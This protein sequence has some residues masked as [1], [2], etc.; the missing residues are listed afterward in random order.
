[1]DKQL[2]T[3]QKEINLHVSDIK[4][5]QGLLSRLNVAK[6]KTQD[7]LRR[8]KDRARKTMEQLNS[9][10]RAD[11]AE[12]SLKG[13]ATLAAGATAGITGGGDAGGLM[14]FSNVKRRDLGAMM[15]NSLGNTLNS[16]SSYVNNVLPLKILLKSSQMTRFEISSEGAKA[17]KPVNAARFEP[18]GRNSGLQAKI[19]DLLD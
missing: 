4:R 6:G 2:V 18:Q 12:K 1:M 15:T 5:I 17:K 9:H 10:K 14:L 16:H 19:K 8:T 11:A 3:L 7:E 13:G